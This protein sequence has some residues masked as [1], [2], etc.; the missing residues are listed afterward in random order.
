MQIGRA[1]RKLMDEYIERYN[2]AVGKKSDK[3]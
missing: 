1:I 2:K 3:R